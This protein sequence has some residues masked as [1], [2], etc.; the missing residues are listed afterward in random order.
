MIG[1]GS[2]L[3]MADL[4]QTAELTPESVSRFSGFSLD[5]IY[6]G[7]DSALTL[8]ILD[9]IKK[10][11]GANKQ[12]L[13]YDFERA[14]QA[15]A[16][17]MMLRGWKV[18]QYERG[19]AVTELKTNVS[20]LSARL[21]QM[22]RVFVGEPLNPK[23]A[24]RKTGLWVNHN[25][26]KQLQAFFYK[27]MHLPEVWT[28]KAGKRS[29][30]MDREALEKIGQNY[31][32]QPIV[33]AIL[34]IRED[35]KSIKV[36]E[37]EIDSDGRIRTS[38]NIAA[39]ETGRWSSSK[40]SEG[41]GGNLQNWKE[42]LRRMLVADLGW[43][44]CGIDLEQADA[45]EIGFTMGVLFDDWTYLNACEG[46]DLHTST[47]RLVWPELSWRGDPRSD[48]EIAER[49]FYRDFS[50]RDMSKRGGHGTTY[51]GSPWTMARHLKVPVKVMEGFQERFFGAYPSIPRLHLW[52]AR[53]LQT[54]FK[55]TTYFGR[56]RH[57]FG[58]PNDD[59]TL[60]E[61]I[62]FLGQS[63]TADRM[64]RGVYN[65][66]ERLRHRIRLVGQLHDAVYFLY[67][68]D[69][70]EES[71]VIPLALSCCDIPVVAPSGRRFSVPGEAKVGWNMSR[72]HDES[73]ALDAKRNPFNPNGLVKW[74]LG[75]ADKRK[76][77]D[78]EVF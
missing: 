45:R 70:L 22:F 19:K 75:T 48:R 10:L 30:S 67:R 7:L 64:S 54:N 36:L 33:A 31:Y 23:P 6:G 32:A 18:D 53:E 68:D 77:L 35:E 37:T 41:T 74:K 20:S 16:L 72:R 47:A 56:E 57:F 3:G 8:E 63:P 61:A 65:L 40:S 2:I 5:Q 73:K 66:W 28:S 11:E 58:R 50:F 27:H 13:I 71:E 4:I 9:E 39:T 12:H 69:P 62:A 29:L 15:P 52:G 17:D 55:L 46:G 21:Q 24:F 60:R 59:A 34:S 51:L 78:G 49:I 1:K 14:L 25:S 42:R 44:V 76:R 43:K 26:T 38:Y